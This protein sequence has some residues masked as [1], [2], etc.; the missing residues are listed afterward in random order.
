MLKFYHWEYLKNI[1]L[2]EANWCTAIPQFQILPS[3]RCY[4]TCVRRI[5]WEEIDYDI[6]ARK[7]KQY[8]LSR[9]DNKIHSQQAITNIMKTMKRSELVMVK[10]IK[11]NYHPKDPQTVFVCTWH[12]KLKPLS[13]L[14]YQKY[15][16]TNTDTTL[17]KTFT[18]KNLSK[19][20]S[21]AKQHKLCQLVSTCKTI[22][23]KKHRS[24][25][26]H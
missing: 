14:L 25:N 13:S 15:K 7:L 12:P 11:L 1:I 20:T 19:I 6:H 18:S 16:T 21:G 5:C 3:P 9:S 4:Q 17:S 22:T 23:K 24:N 2:Y 10:M 8:F 26:W